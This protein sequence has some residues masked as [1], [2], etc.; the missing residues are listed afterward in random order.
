MIFLAFPYCRPLPK[1]QWAVAYICTTNYH[2]LILMQAT[3]ERA[4]GGGFRRNSDSELKLKNRCTGSTNHTRTEFRCGTGLGV[5]NKFTKFSKSDWK[6]ES[7]PVGCVPP[8]FMVRGEGILGVG[9]IPLRYP[10]P[11]YL[12]SN[13]LSSDTQPPGYPAPCIL[14]LLDTLPLG[15]PTPMW[16]EWHMIMNTLDF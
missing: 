8:A 15:Y 13:T 3:A 2:K 1:G 16:T 5:N 12:T 11:G 4:M 6:Q 14:Y 10:T 9:Y 7:I